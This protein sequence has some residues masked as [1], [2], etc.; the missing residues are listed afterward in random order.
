MV[1][2]KIKWYKK[3]IRYSIF[4]GTLTLLSFAGGS[5]F[6]YKLGGALFSKLY[7]LMTIVFGILTLYWIWEDRK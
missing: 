5:Y 4:F 1:K 6:H 3:G 7:Y 2:K